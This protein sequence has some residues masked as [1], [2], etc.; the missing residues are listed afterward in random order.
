MASSKSLFDAVESRRS[1]YQLDKSSTISDARVKEIVEFALLHAPSAFNSQSAR[2]VIL[3]NEDHEKVWDITKEAL[4]GILPPERFEA[5]AGRINGFRAAH[6]SIL[7][8]EDSDTTHDLEKS[9][10]SYADRVPGWSHHT[11]GIHQYIIWT[12]L[13]TE[14]LGANL[15]HYNPLID[16]K[17]KATWKIPQQWELHA[18]LVFGKPVGSPNEKTFKPL[19]ERLKVYGAQE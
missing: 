1:I 5:S 8:F 6:G 10:P 17:V 11:S 9:Y 16:E 15:Q 12:A 19:E 3:L 13:E 4:Q 7:F 14:G 2:I 18:Q